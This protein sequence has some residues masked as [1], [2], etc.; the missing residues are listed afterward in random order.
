MKLIKSEVWFR[1]MMINFRNY[2]LPI[3]FI[4]VCFL[5]VMAIAMSCEDYDPYEEKRYEEM[6]DSIKNVGRM[7]KTASFQR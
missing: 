3:L 4:Y 1:E 6:L 7:P 2:V 5:L